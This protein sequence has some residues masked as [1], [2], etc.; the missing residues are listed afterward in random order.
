M[1]P[2]TPIAFYADIVLIGQAQTVTEIPINGSESGTITLNIPVGTPG[3]TD[4]IAVVDDIGDGTG[5]VAETDETNNAFILPID[6]EQAGLNLGPNIE[7]CIGMTVTLD[8]GITDPLFTFQ[9]FL[10][11]VAITGAN[12]PSIDV[13]TNGTYSVEAF[14][15]ICFVAGTIDVSFNPQ[16]IANPAAHFSVTTV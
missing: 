16:P 4:L 10:N 8:T 7:S 1:P 5:I 15:G 2:N 9:W 12:G 11:G 6:L 13:T 3:I 14:E